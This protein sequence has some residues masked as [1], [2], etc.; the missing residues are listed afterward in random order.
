MCWNQGGKTQNQIADH[1]NHYN[2]KKQYEFGHYDFPV[3]D[4]K[5]GQEVVSPVLFFVFL[6]SG[7]GSG[8]QYIHVNNPDMVGSSFDGIPIEQEKKAE[9]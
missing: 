9:D 5:P 8:H 1:Q 7:Y 3:T 2:Q 6:H 4:G